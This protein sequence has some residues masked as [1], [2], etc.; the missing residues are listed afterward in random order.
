MIN[1]IKKDFVEL[2]E[3][4]EA[5]SSKKVSAIMPELLELMTRK[6]NSSGH[7]TTFHKIGDETVAVF[8]YYHKTWE[9]VSIADY[10]KKANTATGLNTMC[11]E[12]VSTWTRQQRVKK[13]SES[14]LLTKV[15]NGEVEPI[16][17]GALMKQIQEDSKVITPRED[18][19]GFATLEECLSS[20]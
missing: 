10:G 16:E 8:C 15:A 5:N 11:K 14:E 13:Q 12:G 4:L 18:G 2:Y 9:V 7:A 17:L 6:V 20:L 3:I 1:S 19:H